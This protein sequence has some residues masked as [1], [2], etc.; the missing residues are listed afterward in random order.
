[1]INL[2]IIK[3]LV[4]FSMDNPLWY[5]LAIMIGSLLTILVTQITKKSEYKNEA[6]KIFLERRI[7]RHEELYQIL[8]EAQLISW[9]PGDKVYYQIFES[10]EKMNLWFNKMI[11]FANSNSLYFTKNVMLELIFLNNLFKQINVQINTEKYTPEQ[12][13]MFCHIN[14]KEL[15]EIFSNTSS[16]IR[17]YFEN[18][19]SLDYKLNELND[20]DHNA[21]L[22]RIN[23]L[24]LIKDNNLQQTHIE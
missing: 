8:S 23:N 10:P 5:I 22:N 19:I 16:V 20:K 18:D 13:K 9:M 7:E 17:N 15:Q 12:L 11:N 4:F 2:T 14:Y 3:N 21:R 6:K 24:K 1:M